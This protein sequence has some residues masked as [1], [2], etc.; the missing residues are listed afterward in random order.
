M[1]SDQH[2]EPRQDSIS[3]LFGALAAPL[4]QLIAKLN[5]HQVTQMATG[6]ADLGGSLAQIQQ[7]LESLDNTAREI[8]EQLGAISDFLT[9]SAESTDS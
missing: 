8:S 4:S 5:V 1:S 7:R 2:G 9:Q 3:D 6:L